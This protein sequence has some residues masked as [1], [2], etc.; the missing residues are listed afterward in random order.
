ML[1]VGS[2]KRYIV[3]SLLFVFCV[4]KTSITLDPDFG[5]HLRFGQLVLQHGIP[6]ID[7]FSYTMPRYHFI[8]HEWL[9]DVLI[10]MTYPIIHMTGLAIIASALII[11]TFLLTKRQTLDVPFLLCMGLSILSSSTFIAVRPQIISWLFFSIILICISSPTIWQR[12][13]YFLPLLFLLWANM[14]G[15]FPMGLLALGIHIIP[16][17]LK[18]KV[19]GVLPKRSKGDGF[20]LLLCLLITL[21]NP[22]GFSLWTEIW[23][24]IADTSLRWSIA[25]W[26]PGF[27]LPNVGFWIFLTL[28]CFFLIHYKKHYSLQEKLLFGIFLILG[29]GTS[30]HL[31]FWILIAI[32]ITAKALRIFT[33]EV[34]AFVHGEKRLHIATTVCITLIIVFGGIQ[35]ILFFIL[36][37]T[38]R[39]NTFYP[40]QA[41]VYIKHALPSGNIFSYYGWGGY[42]IWK[43]PDKKVF[44]DGRMPSWKQANAHA[45]E[46]TYAFGEYQA[47][48]NGTI[49]LSTIVKKYQITTFLLP[50]KSK[51]NKK[52]Y[53][54]L[55]KYH[56]EI[57]YNDE[58]ASIYQQKNSAQTVTG[59]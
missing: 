19:G 5:W 47:V 44:I 45:N 37:I 54:Q 40:T 58:I 15:G 9:T 2:M 26:M 43:I 29:L 12:W 35:E 30:R 57:V 51:N 39:T 50:R 36:P 7:P 41:L 53:A 48:M 24:S 14:H 21:I 31:P 20:I 46:S 27:M 25:E 42:L 6:Y 22:Y 56:W 4:Y 10:A 16:P 1:Q 34:H 49:P 38:P 13:R 11:A 23:K 8:N 18:R 3:L 32:P 55:Q 17:L 28:S 52:L 33:K 59:R